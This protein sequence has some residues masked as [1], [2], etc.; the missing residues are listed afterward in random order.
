MMPVE[1]KWEGLHEHLARL[2]GFF[3]SYHGCFDFWGCDGRKAGSVY[4]LI[5]WLM[6][7]SHCVFNDLQK[8]IVPDHCRCMCH[9]VTLSVSHLS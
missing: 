3:V 9:L 7:P 8:G 1:A 4:L 6:H 5:R 2:L